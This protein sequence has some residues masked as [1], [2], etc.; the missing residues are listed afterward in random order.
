[1]SAFDDLK[2]RVAA[3]GLWNRW[4]LIAVVVVVLGIGFII[5]QID[6]NKKREKKVKNEQPDV[7]IVRGEKISGIEQFEMQLKSIQRQLEEL[8]SVKNDGE[9]EKA[10]KEKIEALEK[11]VESLSKIAAQTPLAVSSEDPSRAPVFTPKPD[12]KGPGYDVLTAPLPLPGGNPAALPP[13]SPAAAPTTPGQAPGL[14]KEAQEQ[15]P[16]QRREIRIGMIDANGAGFDPAKFKEKREEEFS[17][18]FEPKKDPTVFMPAG[19]MFSAV[20]LTGVD[21][22]TSAAT[23]QNPVPVVFRVK[24]EAILPNFAS[25]DV[26]E[27]FLLGSGYGQ[28]SSERA[29]LRAE[30]LTCVTNRGK[31]LEAPFQAFVVG[32]DG[33]VGIPGR[34]VS[35][36]GAMIA[37]ALIG[38]I[39]GGLAGGAQPSAVP[40]LN[41][42]N[43]DL[44]TDPDMSQIARSGFAG[45][46]QSAANS[47]AQFYLQMA[48]ETFPVVEISAGEAATI[49]VTVGGALPLKGSTNLKPIEEQNASSAK[50][51]NAKKDAAAAPKETLQPVDMGDSKTPAN[52]QNSSNPAWGSGANF[53]KPSQPPSGLSGVSNVVN[54]AIKRMQGTD[55]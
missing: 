52:G 26:R 15:A 20:L 45:G 18:N 11:Q 54:E 8:G 39:F 9:R 48:K 4:P 6:G 28:L 24:R 38:G 23:Q 2:N 37:R 10:L 29:I 7:S 33:K 41:L 25:I 22:P 43:R 21:M 35:K 13:S 12:N 34:L 47:I 51:A 31:V 40:R 44:W 50:P 30:A 49:V 36:Q 17:K 53:G 5:S 32:P 46:M 19:S 55:N 27:C 1:M 42:G 16:P 3:S 14:T